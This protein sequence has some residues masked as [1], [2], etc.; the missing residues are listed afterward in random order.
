[1]R[2]LFGLGCAVSR[3]LK[4]TW[5]CGFQGCA[6]SKFAGFNLQGAKAKK[7]PESRNVYYAT[8]NT[9]APTTRGGQHTKSPTCAAHTVCLRF[10]VGRYSSFVNGAQQT[11]EEPQKIR[12][13]RWESCR[14]RFVFCAVRNQGGRVLNTTGAQQTRVQ[15]RKSDVGIL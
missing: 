11:R 3:A 13:V 2:L 5:V 8:K 1:M 9:R 14:Q 7:A 10:G 4:K 6:L 12:R 15:K